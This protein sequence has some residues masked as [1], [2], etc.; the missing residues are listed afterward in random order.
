L[1]ENIFICGRHF[2]QIRKKGWNE[3]KIDF[4]R[5]IHKKRENVHA[6]PFTKSPPTGCPPCI[7]SETGDV[8][9]ISCVFVCKEKSPPRDL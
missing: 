8:H 7:R 5:F 3:R 4:I 9:S 2:L 1:D 6:K